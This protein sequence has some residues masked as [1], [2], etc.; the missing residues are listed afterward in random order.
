[1][2]GGC[3][4]NS[5]AV[6]DSGV[7]TKFSKGGG[8]IERPIEHIVMLQHSNKEGVILNS[9]LQKNYPATF[10]LP[11]IVV[12]IIIITLKA[13]LEGSCLDFFLQRGTC[14]CPRN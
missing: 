1:V 2:S 5:T 13:H 3:R 12:N 4:N 6:A 14:V 8:E 10:L 9:K 7:L 11:I